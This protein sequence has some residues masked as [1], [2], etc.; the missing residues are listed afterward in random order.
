MG[1]DTHLDA[2]GCGARAPGS[3]VPVPPLSLDVL[4]GCLYLTLLGVLLWRMVRMVAQ[5]PRDGDRP[6]SLPSEEAARTSR[7]RN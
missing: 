6:A 5:E 7:R 4:L 2:Y 1:N 3:V